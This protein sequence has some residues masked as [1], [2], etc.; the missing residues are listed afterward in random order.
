MYVC[1]VCMCVCMNVCVY[2]VYIHICIYMYICMC[3]YVC[4]YC[5][6]MENNMAA[7]RYSFL[8][9]VLYEN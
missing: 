6:R 5:N 8:C 2:V 1:N 3:V 7:V 4:M 9:S